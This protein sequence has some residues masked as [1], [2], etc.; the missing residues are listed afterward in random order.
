MR[1]AEIR[2]AIANG[3]GVPIEPMSVWHDSDHS[4]SLTE[5]APKHLPEWETVTEAMK[6]FIAF[7]VGRELNN[8][9]A[10]TSHIHH[11]I[12]ARWDAA[13]SDYMVNVEQRLRR[14]LKVLGIADLAY[15]YVIETRTKSGRS[16]TRPHLHG[17]CIV[18]EPLMATKLHLSLEAAFNPDITKKGRQREIEVKPAY[19]W[20]NEFI[21][22]DRWVSYFIKNVNRW[23]RRLGKRRVFMSHSMIR[24]AREAWACRREEPLA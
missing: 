7:D 19:D 20:N 2:T 4:W 18:D 17:F 14:K 23:D 11:G 24:L 16:Q 5:L 3:H 12:R 10:F 8:C 15:C 1:D 9:F 6:M 21:G 22:R 13:G